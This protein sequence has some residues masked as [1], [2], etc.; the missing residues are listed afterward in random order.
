MRNINGILTLL[1][2]ISI[3]VLGFMV[4]FVDP[5][6][7]YTY[8]EYKISQEGENPE[9]EAALKIRIYPKNKEFL[10]EK[11]N[12][13]LDENYLYEKLH[14]LVH[15]YLPELQVSLSN[16]NGI[17]TYFESN[18]NNLIAIAGITSAD[19]LSKL[20]LN[21][22]NKNIA[23]T[24]YVDAEILTNTYLEDEKY[25]MVDVKLNYKTTAL[26]FKIYIANDML[27]SPMVILE[28][29]NGGM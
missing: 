23:E 12:G 24:E 15:K 11:Y 1:I 25:D 2:I 29:I 9:L 13:N 5:I 8:E 10:D 6:H 16:L 22:Q 28:S 19:E 3:A 26:Y 14:Q 18:K 21:L 4:F 27:T 20:A 7:E 17:S